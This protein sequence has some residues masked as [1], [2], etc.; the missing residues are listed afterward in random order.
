MGELCTGLSNGQKAISMLELMLND[1]YEKISLTQEE[2]IFVAS[3]ITSLIPDF[4]VP[5]SGRIEC[6]LQCSDCGATPSL[7]VDTHQQIATIARPNV[8]TIERGELSLIDMS[9]TLVE[10]FAAEPTGQQG[11]DTVE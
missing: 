8:C 7:I 4:V 2:R 9:Q 5:T 6:N 1:L 10:I 3:K 11:S